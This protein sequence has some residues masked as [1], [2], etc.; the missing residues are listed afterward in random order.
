MTIG[1]SQ[2]QARRLKE[3]G[4]DSGSLKRAFADAGER[5]RVFQALESAL[6]EGLRRELRKLQNCGL[7][8]RLCTL[9]SELVAAL[10]ARGFCQ[11]VTPTVMSRAH[12]ARMSIREGH[13]LFDQVYWLSERQCLRPMLAPHLYSLL[14]DLQ[15]TWEPPIRLF[16]VG[17]C[18][19]KDTQGTRHAG[20]FTML[21]LVEMG[22]PESACRQ[23]LEE[24]V[25]GI[26]RAAGVSGYRLV[27]EDSAVYGATTDIMAPEPPGAAQPLAAPPEPGVA[28]PLEA[29]PSL[30]ELGSAAW[31]PH[32][33]DRAWGITQAWVGVG[34]GLERLLMA[35]S[36]GSMSR[37]ARSLGYLDGA[38]LKL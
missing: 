32:P 10:T 24:L 2:V 29:S 37:W 20:E 6:A 12:L 30:L 13:P 19:R 3:L 36:G 5:D 27:S 23:R 15:R 14:R 22:L 17:S 38:R 1:W 7:R 28:Q 4:A 26:M 25:E 31:G 21:N 18:F 9:E 33:L 34:F 8:P 16:E 35:R 11:V